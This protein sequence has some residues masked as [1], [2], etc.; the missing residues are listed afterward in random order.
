MAM[1]LIVSAG[2]ENHP[3][4]PKS[5]DFYLSSQ[6]MM[7]SDLRQILRSCDVL[8]IAWQQPGVAHWSR[9][10]YLVGND[11]QWWP[12]ARTAPWTFGSMGVSVASGLSGTGGQSLYNY[13]N[14]RPL[15]VC[16]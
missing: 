10:E 8:E 1:G 15:P 4:A 14:L 16:T 11:E 12:L 9:A 7:S 5:A 6:A 13:R 2:K 3:L